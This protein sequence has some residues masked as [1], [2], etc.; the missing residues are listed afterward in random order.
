MVP[1]RHPRMPE[2]TS[3]P[4]RTGIA[5]RKRR[6]PDSSPRGGHHR[7]GTVPAS[8]R[9]RCGYV[10][11]G[12]TGASETY[13]SPLRNA[14]DLSSATPSRVR[15]ECPDRG[16]Y[17][18]PD[19]PSLHNDGIVR[20]TW[21][22]FRSRRVTLKFRASERRHPA[23]G[24]PSRAAREYARPALLAGL[25]MQNDPSVHPSDPSGS[26]VEPD[27]IDGSGSAA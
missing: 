7:C 5:D 21:F 18:Q 3:L 19:R 15:T 16:R 25:G 6:R 2:R 13:T 22:G 11:P 1:L 9:L 24:A 10:T 20:P 23:D 17:T 14:N 26:E 27:P 8:H 12:R 4:P